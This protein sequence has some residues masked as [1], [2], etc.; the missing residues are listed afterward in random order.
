MRT[1]NQLILL[2]VEDDEQIRNQFA[3]IFQRRF[4]YVHLA[5]NGQQGLQLF[6]QLQ[7]DLVISDINM[8]V[9][10]GLTMVEHI[11]ELNPEQMIILITA[12]SE[13]E[14]L[15]RAIEL[16]INRYILKPVN[17]RNL[18]SMLD[19]AIEL[20]LLRKQKQIQ[21]LLRIKTLEQSEEMV[22]VTDANG[23]ITEVNEAV[24]HN[25]GYQ[26][27]E[28]YGH[29]PRIFKSGKHS[30]YLY[31]NLWQTITNKQTFEGVFINRRKD[32]SHYYEMKTIVPI[33]GKNGQISHYISTGHNV[34]R[35]R[36]LH[37]RQFDITTTLMRGLMHQF[38]N[39]LSGISGFTYIAKQRAKNNAP[40]NKILEALAN[41]ESSS[42]RMVKVMKQLQPLTNRQ[43]ALPNATDIRQPLADLCDEFKEKYTT[44]VF[45]YSLESLPETLCE[46]SQIATA[47]HELVKNAVDATADK[48]DGQIHIDASAKEIHGLHCSSCGELLHEQYLT[49]EVR[50][51]G[52]GIEPDRLEQIWHPFVSDKDSL[53]LVGN[54][55]G[56]GLTLVRTTIYS[57]YGHI[58]LQSE[59]DKGTSVTLLL[60]IKD[61]V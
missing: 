12:F 29:T 25:S 18:R 42:E 59:L 47:L 56:I 9:M 10:D 43:I 3:E 1:E 11:R 51:N 23:V 14:R 61:S 48:T 21:E 49:I 39:L 50:D 20:L 35:E 6:S 17:R 40:P 57:N 46:W 7:P 30:N 34:T 58:L 36:N 38:N 60:R 15:L 44:P 8:P 32:G 31:K 52:C 54:T 19:E 45:C 24:I 37:E 4:G 5:E 26:R 41:V 2:Y 27:H 16:G 53:H 55:L 33:V 28:L 13:Q 22:I